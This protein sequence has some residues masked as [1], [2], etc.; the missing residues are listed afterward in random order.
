MCLTPRLC[1]LI[2]GPEVEHGAH[3]PILY[4]PTVS[5]IGNTVRKFPTHGKLSAAQ[6]SPTNCLSALTSV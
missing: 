3:F 6:G 5:I 4:Y 1:S 2:D